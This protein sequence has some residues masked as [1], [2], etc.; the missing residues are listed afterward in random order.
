[1]TRLF[2]AALALALTGITT[3]L[4]AQTSND[5]ASFEQAQ[6]TAASIGKS[7]GMLLFGYVVLRLFN[8][9]RDG[10]E[11][12]GKPWRIGALLLVL[13]LMVGLWLSR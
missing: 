3:A 11:D 5:P 1:M 6:S 4:F 10:E 12:T 7:L 8:R 9:P 2:H 13:L